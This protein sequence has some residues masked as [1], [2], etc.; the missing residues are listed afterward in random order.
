MLSVLMSVYWKE[1]PEFLDAALHSIEVQT[2][3]ADEIV[4]VKDPVGP[5]LEAV[6]DAYRTRL[7]LTVIDMPHSVGFGEAMRIGVEKCRGDLIARMDT[8]DVCL[9]ERFHLQVDY[10][11]AHPEIDLVGGAIAEFATNPEQPFAIR[12]VPCLH[13]EI[14]KMAPFRN[15]INHMTVMFRRSAVLKSGN[16]HD[17]A[18]IEDYRLWARMLLAGCRF[19]NLDET[20]VLARTGNGFLKRRG[21]MVKLRHELSMQNYFRQIGFTSAGVYL[22]NLAVR[23]SVYLVPTVVRKIM[24]E[25]LLRSSISSANPG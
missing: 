17:D 22:F 14:A 13:E 25:G 11:D 10:L 15:P 16:Y 2:R 5:E 21:G 20:L 6:I 1:S 12:K 4:L 9:P 7:P 24:Y 3:Q 18:G 8:D 23:T 19:H